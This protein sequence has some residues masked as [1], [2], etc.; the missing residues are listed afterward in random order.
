M[1]RM[2]K[3]SKQFFVGVVVVIVGVVVVDK[4]DEGA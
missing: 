4:R 3:V 2:R 1:F